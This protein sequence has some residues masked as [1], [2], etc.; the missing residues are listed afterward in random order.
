MNKAEFITLIDNPSHLN[1]SHIG[2]LK[3]IAADFPYFQANHILLTKA[4]FTETL[5]QIYYNQGAYKKAIR[6]YEK[7][8]LI[9]PHKMSLFAALIQKIKEESKND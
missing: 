4:L 7:L 1:K 5:A 6:A 8:C 9:Y 2:A 3:N